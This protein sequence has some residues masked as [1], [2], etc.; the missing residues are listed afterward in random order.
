MAAATPIELLAFDAAYLSALER[1]DA[2]TERHFFEY[3]TPLIRAKL[4][5]HLHTPELIDE[6]MQETFMR[7]LSA[8]RS[9]TGVRHPE[10]FGAFV[11]AVCRNVALETWRVERRFAHM[12]DSGA[13]DLEPG[14]RPDGPFRSPHA[15]AEADEAK[16]RVRQVLAELSR[17]DRQLLEAVFLNEE[18]RTLLCLR[19]GV[20]RG[21]LRVLLHRASK[22]FRAAM[23]KE[24][25]SPRKRPARVRGKA[26]RG[27][28]QLLIALRGGRARSAAL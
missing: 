16:T 1:G 28:K 9:K 18:D 27:Q 12:D 10:R 17:P 11:H 24:S 21:H 19:L 20:S 23:L 25:S 22:R 6:A 3:F 8:L 13:E 15:M 14:S 2:E 26:R 4:R 5:K 7:V